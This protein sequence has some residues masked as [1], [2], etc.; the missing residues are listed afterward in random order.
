MGTQHQESSPADFFWNRFRD[1]PE[2]SNAEY[3]TFISE[4]LV[5]LRQVA[6]YIPDE[7]RRQVSQLLKEIEADAERI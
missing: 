4:L 2:A 1:L 6:Q 3:Q 7:Q 5:R